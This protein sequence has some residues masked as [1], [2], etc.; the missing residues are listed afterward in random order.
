[1]RLLETE[2]RDA[3]TTLTAFR[4]FHAARTTDFRGNSTGVLSVVE[5]GVQ[6][7]IGAHRL[8]QIEAEW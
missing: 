8:L 7:D 5:G 6:F 1:L 4:A 2:G 3:H